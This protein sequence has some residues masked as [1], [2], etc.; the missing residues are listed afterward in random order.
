MTVTSQQRHL[1]PMEAFCL[2]EIMS[3]NQVGPVCFWCDV[4]LL[5]P[6]AAQLSTKVTTGSG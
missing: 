5:L 1:K 6:P 2:W 4:L 3:L